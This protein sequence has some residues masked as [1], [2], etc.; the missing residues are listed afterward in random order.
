MQTGSKD[1]DST[2]RVQYNLGI[3]KA[4]RGDVDG[5]VG[6]WKQL[7]A[8]NPKSKQASRSMLAAAQ[9]FRQVNRLTEATDV[10][11]KFLAGGTADVDS[12][13][14][15]RQILETLQKL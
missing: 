10:L 4:A 2:L 7:A 5:A 8:E 12:E 15:A 6:L 1:T 11:Q 13:A 14:T 3:V 9:T